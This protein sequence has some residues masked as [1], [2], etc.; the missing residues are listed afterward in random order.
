MTNSIIPV[1]FMYFL[2]LCNAFR[3]C[4][5][6]HEYRDVVL[7]VIFMP[8]YTMLYVNQSEHSTFELVSSIS[9]D[10]RH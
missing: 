10:S 8:G 5:C 4:I 6:K 1:E 2:I 7:L 3:E 9:Q